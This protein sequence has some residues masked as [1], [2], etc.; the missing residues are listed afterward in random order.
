[1]TS[2]LCIFFCLFSGKSQPNS[3][4]LLVDKVEINTCYANFQQEFNGWKVNA[5]APAFR[6]LIIYEWNEQ[7][8][9]YHVKSWLMIGELS[10]IIEKFPN[11][12][13]IKNK[14]HSLLEIKDPIINKIGKYYYI[15]LIVDKKKYRIRTKI[16]EYS[17]TDSEDDPERAN[18]KLFPE[19]FR[20]SVW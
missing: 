13:R 17:N 2:L 19:Q 8:T 16:L 18:K 14:W 5:Y 7:Y 3:T 4:D 11:S 6:Q 10:P 9:R 15:T 20:E 1:M 12:E